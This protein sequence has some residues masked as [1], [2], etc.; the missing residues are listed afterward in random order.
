M[1]PA[2]IVDTLRLES[3]RPDQGAIA[4]VGGNY[5]PPAF[6]ALLTEHYEFVGRVLY[7]DLYRLL[8]Q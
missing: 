2:Y 8:P 7:A 6:A 4:R 1:R 5:Y 3:P